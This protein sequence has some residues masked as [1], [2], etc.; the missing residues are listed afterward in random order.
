MFWGY[1]SFSGSENFYGLKKFLW[2]EKFSGK[3]IVEI[4]NF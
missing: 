4:N 2:A 1:K 3:N